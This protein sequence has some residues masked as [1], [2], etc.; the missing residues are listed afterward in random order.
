MS[1]PRWALGGALGELCRPAG[2]LAALLEPQNPLGKAW[3]WALHR[4]RVALSGC[5]RVSS[6]RAVAAAV[7]PEAA[8]K[9]GEWS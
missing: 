7:I 8:G 4:P 9:E 6:G 1:V 2:E 5:P 3:A